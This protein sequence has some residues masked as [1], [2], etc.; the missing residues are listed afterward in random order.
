MWRH[1]EEKLEF[2]R[3]WRRAMDRGRR[4]TDVACDKKLFVQWLL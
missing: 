3:F 4:M 1:S 2:V